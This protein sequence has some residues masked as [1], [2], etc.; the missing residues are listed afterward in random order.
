MLFDPKERWGRKGGACEGRSGRGERGFL[1]SEE[2]L[3]SNFMWVL[4]TLIGF[5]LLPFL[6]L[7]VFVLFPP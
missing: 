6:F 7:F 1:V 5:L 2:V 4:G 3:T